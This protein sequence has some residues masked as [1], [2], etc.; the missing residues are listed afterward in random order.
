MYVQL[1][2]FMYPIVL[3]YKLYSL[4]IENLPVTDLV[5]FDLLFGLVIGTLLLVISWMEY[6]SDIQKPVSLH[7]AFHIELINETV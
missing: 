1:F 6:S 2:T 4:L 5:V 3:M 7:S